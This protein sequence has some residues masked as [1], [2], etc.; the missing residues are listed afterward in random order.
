MREN[1]Q[2]LPGGQQPLPGGQQEWAGGGSDRWRDSWVDAVQPVGSREVCGR[3]AQQPWGGGFVLG[4]AGPT[5]DAQHGHGLCWA[6]RPQLTQAGGDSSEGRGGWAGWQHWEESSLAC[7]GVSACVAHM[8]VAHTCVCGARVG[9]C[10]S[11]M[12][13]CTCVVHTCAWGAW[14]A[15]VRV[16]VGCTWYRRVGCICG[17]ACGA[18]V[19][20]GEEGG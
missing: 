19:C 9:G 10:G 6:G 15:H 5:A 16:G 17:R 2:P 18:H 8:R 20:V 13:M 7:R 4:S 14:G 12:C 3:Q 11:P 1:R